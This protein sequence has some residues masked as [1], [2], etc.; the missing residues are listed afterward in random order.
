VSKGV[1]PEKAIKL[2]PFFYIAFAI[3]FG[4]SAHLVNIT[5]KLPENDLANATALVIEAGIGIA[6]TWTVYL[7]SKRMHEEN[8]KQQINLQKIIEEQEQ[9]KKRRHDFSIHTIRSY[10][11]EIQHFIDEL[12][13]KKL[14]LIANVDDDAFL[15]SLSASRKYLNIAIQNIWFHVSNSLDVIEPNN[16]ENLRDF[17]QIMREYLEYDLGIDTKSKATG[18]KAS[19]VKLLKELPNPPI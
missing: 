11:P 15:D 8:K 16:I 14:E 12:E 4:L 17:I 13:K 3:I 10:L 19:I 1:N 18:I 7:Y 2:L 6:I 5:I 9:F